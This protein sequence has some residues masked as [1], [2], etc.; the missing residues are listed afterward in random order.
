MRS[1]EILAG[2]R[3][4]DL[5]AKERRAYSDAREIEADETA[6]ALADNLNRKTRAKGMT[7]AELLAA[8]RACEAEPG[9]P[10]YDRLVAEIEARCLDI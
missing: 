8:Y 7:D 6:Q 5:S 2:R 10:A 4:A 1:D 9:D 3:L